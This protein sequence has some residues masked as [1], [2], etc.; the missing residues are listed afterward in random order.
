[1][2]WGGGDGEGWDYEGGKEGELVVVGLASGCSHLPQRKGDLSL[3]KPPEVAQ[4]RRPIG[5]Q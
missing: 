5:L 3:R 2:F 1:M 4:V